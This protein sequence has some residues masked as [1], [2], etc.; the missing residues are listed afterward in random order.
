MSR[1]AHPK[2]MVERAQ[3]LYSRNQPGTKLYTERTGYRTIA[4]TLSAE[5]GVKVGMSTVRD[6]VTY[7]SRGSIAA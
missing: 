3:I 4:E 7:H 2:A 6:W 1:R 5:F